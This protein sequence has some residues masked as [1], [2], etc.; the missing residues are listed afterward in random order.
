MHYFKDHG[1][2]NISAAELVTESE[3]GRIK[4]KCLTGDSS[5]TLKLVYRT[6]YSVFGRQILWF[7]DY[8]AQQRD[9]TV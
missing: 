2:G 3:R 4:P 6:E 1:P 8:S 5:I 7:P 9:W